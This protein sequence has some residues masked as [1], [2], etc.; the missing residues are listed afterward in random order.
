M[1]DKKNFKSF[2]AITDSISEVIGLKATNE[3]ALDKV[4]QKRVDAEVERRATLL[5]KGFDKYNTTQ[6][7]LAQ[8]GPDVVTHVVTAASKGDDGE[9]LVQKAYSDKRMKEL[10][11][12]R[13]DLA[14]LDAAFLKAYSEGN[15]EPLMKLVGGGNKPENGKPEKGD[16]E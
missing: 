12:L 1:A 3:T 9:A 13:Q 7:A 8:C 14:A 16:V 15:Y 11:K 4:I 5:E 10:Q 2:A 6:K